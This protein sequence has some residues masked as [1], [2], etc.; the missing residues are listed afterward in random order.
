[1][2][3]WL[4]VA[5]ITA[6]CAA[7]AQA[8]AEAAPLEAPKPP[9]VF[10]GNISLA[11]QYVFRGLS[12]TDGHPALQGGADYSHVSG[13]YAGMWL[14]NISW[15]TDQNANIRS[16]PVSLASP[17]SVGAPYAPNRSNAASLEWDFYAGIKNNL[18]GGDWFY[19]VGII[20]YFYPGRYENVGAYRRPHTTEVY[21]LLGYH[22][23][24]LKYSKGI[25]LCTFGINE[26][27]GAEYLDLSAVFSLGR[28]GFKL[29]GHVGR[30]N[31]PGNANAAY[32]GAS[33]GNNDYYDYTDYKLGLT[34][35]ALGL[36]F[37][38]VWT[39]AETKETAPDGQ[40]TAYLNA[41]GV[42]IGGHRIG[43]SVSKTF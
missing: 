42:N 14:S 27:R 25:S 7:P 10:S 9:S 20:E 35:D 16:A 39:L 11:S 24:S 2:I 3:Y 4:T 31:F 41:F 30:Y 33:G 23:V 6:F 40:T 18:L 5:A 12:Q 28:S 21:C 36:T 17:G 43:L 15:F 13:L 34:K 38:L 19:D 8:L 1:M 37:G 22:G 29:Q 32:W 26:S